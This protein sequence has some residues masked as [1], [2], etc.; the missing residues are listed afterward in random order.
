MPTL[1]IIT[2]TENMKPAGMS[3]GVDVRRIVIRTI[4]P[5]KNEYVPPH[6]PAGQD[7]YG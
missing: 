1:Q 7:V 4:P 5:L 6:T 2:D 3:V